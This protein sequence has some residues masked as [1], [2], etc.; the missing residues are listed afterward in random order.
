MRSGGR[1]LFGGCEIKVG[2]YPSPYLF[3]I[4]FRIFINPMLASAPLMISFLL[5]D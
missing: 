2:V 1:F 3:K 4:F 5:S